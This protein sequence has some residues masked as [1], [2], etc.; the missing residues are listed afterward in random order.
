MD[1]SEDVQ[2]LTDDSED[3]EEE[4]EEE[5]EGEV[6]M[7]SWSKPQKRGTEVRLQGVKLATTVATLRCSRL[8]LSVQCTRCRHV[9]DITC[10]DKRYAAT[11]CYLYSD[12]SSHFDDVCM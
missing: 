9:M 6:K 12:D 8:K 4:E 2:I 3:E 5:G 1:S 11:A 7:K 10:S